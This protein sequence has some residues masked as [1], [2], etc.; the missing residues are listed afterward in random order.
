MKQKLPEGNTIS[1]RMKRD[2]TDRIGNLAEALGGFEG[3][4][5]KIYGRDCM[6]DIVEGILNYFKGQALKWL[7]LGGT[8]GCGKSV[9]GSVV[10]LLLS[11]QRDYCIVSISRRN[12]VDDK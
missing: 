12:N 2:S 9:V 8:R 7:I 10:A 4:R 5:T 6:I 11:A 1:K 3:G